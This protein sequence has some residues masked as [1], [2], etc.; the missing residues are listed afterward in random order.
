MIMTNLK[1]LVSGVL[2]QWKQSRLPLFKY[3]GISLL[4]VPAAWA[5]PVQQI[6]E[7]TPLARE[8]YNVSHQDMTWQEHD[9]RIFIAASKQALPD[10]RK[11]A[12]LYVLDGNAQFPLAVNAAQKQGA[13]I[14]GT[15]AQSGNAPVSAV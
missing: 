7:I 9:Y 8:I 13:Q 3:M 14:S 15:H 12:A 4:G 10:N 6:P 1:S 5:Q 11:P 2:S